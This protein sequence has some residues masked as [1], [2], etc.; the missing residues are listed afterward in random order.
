MLRMAL[1]QLNDMVYYIEE[2]LDIAEMQILLVQDQLQ[3]ARDEEIRCNT[4]VQRADISKSG[5][6]KRKSGNEFKGNSKK[7]PSKTHET[8]KVYAITAVPTLVATPK[9]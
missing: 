9:S 7:T 5:D 4:L 6:K 2:E 1:S 3:E 8:V